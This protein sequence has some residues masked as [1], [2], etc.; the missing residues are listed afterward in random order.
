MNRSAQTVA[1]VPPAQRVALP[2]AVACSAPALPEGPCPVCPRL[3]EQFEPFRQA[4]YWKRMH[5]L[6]VAR[7]AE[8]RAEVE[9]LRARLRLR[10]QQLFG[11]K[12]EAHPTP[13]EAQTPTE[14]QT[15][16]PHGQQPGKP[17]PVR[18]DH[19]HLPAAE[20]VIDLP[21]GRRH[22]PC[23]GLAFEEFP[24]TEDGQ[25]LEVEVRAYRRVYRR[26]RYRPAC[27]C[28][29]NPGIIAAAPPDKLIPKSTLGISIWVEV[30]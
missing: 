28:E 18:R 1:V 3:A 12:T 29:G 24:G 8:L 23:C 13:S 25:T 20:E 19:S 10:A 21:D 4:A 27:R 9:S 15:P 7:A 22:C 2:T 6:A 14:P 16:R 5:E 17:G 30:L 26:R 11:Q